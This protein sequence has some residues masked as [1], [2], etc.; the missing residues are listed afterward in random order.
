ME[1]KRGEWAEAG[2]VGGGLQEL[3]GKGGAVGR[4]AKRG[5]R[6]MAKG[7]AEGSTQPWW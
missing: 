3:E 6:H 5:G 2:P 7:G 1:M 4:W